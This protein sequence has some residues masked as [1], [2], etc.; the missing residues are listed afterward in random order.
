MSEPIAVEVLSSGMTAYHRCRRR[1]RRRQPATQESCSPR[2]S[3]H[4]G[5]IREPATGLRAVRP[6]HAIDTTAVG[7]FKCDKSGRSNASGTAV[8][9]LACALFPVAE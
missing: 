5:G 9:I 8:F 1:R 3:S 6:S 2:L 7:P 4:K